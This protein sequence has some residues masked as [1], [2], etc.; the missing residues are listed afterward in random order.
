MY[1]LIIDFDIISKRRTIVRGPHPPRMKINSIRD[2][3]TILTSKHFSESAVYLMR[4]LNGYDIQD[5]NHLFICI[6]P[7]KSSIG[8]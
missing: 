3:T 8:S 1:L 4:L 5:L 7:V 2:M 6:Y